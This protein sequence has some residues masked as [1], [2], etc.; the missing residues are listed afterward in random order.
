MVAGFKLTGGTVLS[1]CASLFTI[2]LVLGST[3]EDR[4]SSRYDWLNVNWDTQAWI[5]KCP[6]EDAKQYI[7]LVSY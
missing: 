3:Q 1:P 6:V 4:K 7:V 2:C 5:I